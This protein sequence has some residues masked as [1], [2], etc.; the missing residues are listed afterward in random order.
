MS[1]GLKIALLLV[2]S[3]ALAV[4]TRRSLI[5][6]NK[7]GLFRLLAWI[8][9]IALVLL[10]VDFWFDDPYCAR[11]ITSWLLLAVS[12]VVVIYGLISLHQGRPDARRD[13]PSLIGIE[14]T[15]VLVTSGAYRY[16][17]HPLYSSFLFGACGV[18]LKHLSVAGAFLALLTILFAVM[19][20]KREESENVAYFGDLYR[21]YMKRTRMF[22][23]FLY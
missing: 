19:T 15:T 23:P 16:V 8:S 21:E 5:G 13:D 6:L 12:V 2:V 1:I 14:R 10:N 22:I 9:V 18:L 7:H 3:V 17:R 20:A 11:Q 4:L